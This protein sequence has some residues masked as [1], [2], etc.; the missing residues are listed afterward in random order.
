LN[1]N[2][3]KG[4][5]VIGT[6]GYVLGEM[7]GVD[8]D[9]NTWQASAFYI[10]LSNEATS[11]LHLKKPFLR[12]II[13][14]LPTQLIQS[15]GDIITLKKPVRNLKDIADKEMFVNPAKLEGK[16]VIGAKGYD[17]G[18]VEGLDLDLNNWQIVGLQVGLTE[19]AASELG[20]K[21]PFMSKVVVI[22]PSEII[23]EVGNFITLDK[24]T[25]D[26]KSLVECIKSCQKRNP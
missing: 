22:I 2:L 19:N 23:K 9:L 13:I 20:F 4:K 3:L 24:A 25:E 10:V 26:L 12:K 17:V 16:K 14:C 7:N 15:V 21:T 6:E 18:E 1:P 5:T 8:I 11:E